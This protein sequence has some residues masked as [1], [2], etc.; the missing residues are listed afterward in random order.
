M[1]EPLFMRFIIDGVLLNAEPGLGRRAC[2]ACTRAGAL[3]LGVIVAVEPD[4]AS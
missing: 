3:F 1:I 4:R 2:R